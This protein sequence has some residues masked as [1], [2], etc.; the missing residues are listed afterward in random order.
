MDQAADRRTP[1]A[2]LAEALPGQ[3][4]RVGGTDIDQR[5]ERRGAAFRGQRPIPGGGGETRDAARIAEEGLE[6][7]GH[8][9]D[10]LAPPIVPGH[11]VDRGAD[12]VPAGGPLDAVP[13]PPAGEEAGEAIVEAGGPLAGR[14]LEETRQGGRGIGGGQTACDRT[15]RAGPVGRPGAGDARRVPDGDDPL[16]IERDR[17]EEPDEEH[18]PEIALGAAGGPRGRLRGAEVGA[19]IRRFAGS[20]FRRRYERPGEPCPMDRG[21]ARKRA[22]HR[23]PD[24]GVGLGRREPFEGV[25]REP[26]HARLGRGPPPE[27]RVDRPGVGKE[28]DSLHAHR[29]LGVVEQAPQARLVDRLERPQGP[30]GAQTHGDV[31]PV[32]EELVERRHDAPEFALRLAGG[33]TVGEE[34]DRHPGVP[35][36]GREEADER[37]GAE[38]GEVGA[39][40]DRRRGGVGRGEIEAVD[41]SARAVDAGALVA[42]AGVGPVEDGEGAPRK[43]HQIGAPEEGIAEGG[44]ILLVAAD[45]PA[46]SGVE[47]VDVDPAAVEVEGEEPAAERR[48][49]PR[50]LGNDQAAGVGVSTAMGDRPAVPRFGPVTARVEVVVVG[51]V[52]ERV[53]DVGVRLDGVRAGEV[54]AGKEPPEVAVDG[55][56]EE[57]RAAVVPVEPPG[58]RRPVAERLEDLPLGVVAPDPAAERHARGG[59]AAGRPDLA[60]GTRPRARRPRRVHRLPLEPSHVRQRPG[61]GP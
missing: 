47:P 36:V 12:G 18:R 2:R 56:G 30:Q 3:G 15:A 46:G 9:G 32:V 45:D 16:R 4:R 60:G 44:Q 8:V 53:G 52:A 49:P 26:A 58:V 19:G 57:A 34:A 29:R 59:V 38:G 22:G 23:Q 5:V 7:G 6:P 37:R 1:E 27:D 48:R 43:F 50:L 40:G 41:P 25:E 13:S 11:G 55:V 54:G 24:L 35:A 61:L 28:P 10:R 33:A 21:Q 14:R 17:R 39:D 20:R 31:R 42:F 51:V